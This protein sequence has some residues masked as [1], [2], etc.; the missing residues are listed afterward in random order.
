MQ[1]RIV[2]RAGAV[3]QQ[4]SREQRA[5][6]AARL[7]GKGDD[8]DDAGFGSASAFGGPYQT[9]NAEK[10]LPHY[11]CARL[12]RHDPQRSK[13]VFIWYNTSAMHFRTHCAKK[14]KGKSGQED[15][16]DVM[17]AHDENIGRTLAKLD[18]LGIAEW[19]VR[20]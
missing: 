13:A 19:W 7:V 5:L 15:Y 12:H 14:H 8:A 6:T 1:F 20:C 18:E 3:L 2:V 10:L 9:P 17:V 4:S 11:R 16:D